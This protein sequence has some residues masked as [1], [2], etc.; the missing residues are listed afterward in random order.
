MINE[1]N[2]YADYVFSG[3]KL[4]IMNTRAGVWRVV[5]EK[6]GKFDF[7]GAAQT[8][9]ADLGEELEEETLPVECENKSGKLVITARDGSRVEA[10]A[11]AIAFFNSH[12]EL[13]REIKTVTAKNNY[14]KITFKPEAGEHFF[15]T[16]ERFDSVQRRGKR[17]HIY[18]IDRWCATRGNSYIPI[19]FVI[20]SNG[21][22]LFFN[23]YEHSVFDICKTLPGTAV[24]TQKNAPLDM[25]VFMNDSPRAILQEYSRLTGFAEMPPEWGFGTLVC[26]YH[27]EFS[28]PEGILEMQRQME[29]N[30]FPFDAV[31]TE[32]W[33]IYNRKRWGE[34]KKVSEALH[35]SGKKMMVY[36][37]C[38]RFPKN[39]EED[40]GLDD[41]F[42]VNSGEGVWLKETR[43]MNLLDNF[44]HKKMRCVDLTS[45]R[46]VNKWNEIWD[47]II[48]DVGVDGAK[49]DFCEQFPDRADIAFADGRNPFAAHHWYPTL[50]N[51]YA[52]RRFCTREQGGLD[53]SRGGGIGIQ[54]SPF[55]WA[56]DQRREYFF[57]RAVVRAA[58]S[59]GLSGVPFV[60]WDMGGYRPSFNPFDKMNEEK[61]F[62]RAVEF[63]CFSANIQTH[64]T[65]KRPYDFDEHTKKIYGCYAN[66]HEKLK[67]YLIEQAQI[68]CKTGLPL[69]RHLLLYDPDDKKCLKVED[70][71]MLGCA[72]L[73][74]PVLNRAKKRDIYLPRGEWRNIFTG[75]E[76]SGGRVLKG[77]CAPL[78]KIPV[79]E[80]KG[81]QS[82][83]LAPSL[84]SAEKLIRE[85]NVL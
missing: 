20:S 59:L 32:G 5:G 64:G 17:V 82:E 24:I 72:L 29:K 83:A 34:L 41:S 51:I 80:L 73:V 35:K 62:A 18:A 21:S 75:E 68:A 85:I 67:P 84:E 39:A 65:V 56:G 19:P 8:L 30:G 70:E 26:R 16:G 48:H 1:E 47:E 69:M 57:L 76:F 53:F 33:G 37:Q 27:P 7:S 12:G 46:S 9:S 25:Y 52:H 49:I 2:N 3:V 14:V 71:Y 66:L 50:Y 45:E 61:V 74:A 60:S 54:R 23:R 15:G 31:I 58:L 63:T 78:E 10:G 79:F 55:V 22:A 43:S 77:Y 36:N 13:K 11:G 38:G 6:N 44:H 42:A 28:T 81:A 40:F 4:R